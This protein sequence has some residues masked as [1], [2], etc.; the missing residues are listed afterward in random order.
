MRF[1]LFLVSITVIGCSGGGGE[2]SLGTDSFGGIDTEENV[3]P[4]EAAKAAL[5]SEVTSLQDQ[6]T[7]TNH[8]I[9]LEELKAL[10]K[11]GLLD[12]DELKE[13]DELVLNTK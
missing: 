7:S 13:L 2:R 12:E 8:Q 1:I 5:K 9:S 11:E 4:E 3:A 10:E 6:L